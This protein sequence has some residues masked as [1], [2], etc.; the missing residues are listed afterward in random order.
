MIDRLTR[1][2]PPLVLLVGVCAAAALYLVDSDSYFTL[3]RMAGL[4]P[5]P[6]FLDLH[7]VMSAAECWQRGVDVY[8]ANPCDVLGRLHVYSPLWLRLPAWLVAPQMLTANG[9][10]MALG[11]I[12]A[13]LVL[14]RPNGSGRAILLLLAIVSPDTILALERANVDVL[15]FIASTIAATLLGRAFAQR[16]AGYGLFLLLGLLKFYP[17]VLLA[18]VLRERPAR[19]VALAAGAVTASLLVVLAMRD[20]FV[21]ALANIEPYHV[22]SGTFAA[23]QLP[24]GTAEILGAPPVLTIAL[25]LALVAGAAM[26]VRRLSGDAALVASIAALPAR[27]A[28]LLAV[29]APL[30]I[31]CFV[32]G[33]SVEYRAVF[34]LL[35]LPALFRLAGGTAAPRMFLATAAAIPALMWEPVLRRLAGRGYAPL[36]EAMTLPNLAVWLGREMLWWWVAAVLLGLLLAQFRDAPLPRM[37]LAWLWR[38][39]AAR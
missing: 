14:P 17:L 15:I 22:F 21:R 39:A 32:A 1:V 9:I 18:L 3:R 2:L 5:F 23:R 24:Q 4:Q 30:V 28:N 10:A 38:G 16:V 25:G 36:D 33:Q 7:G 12:M 11:F 20:E 37:G 34:L 31:G 6:L 13:L 19:A 26:L 8:A 29:G 35:T 27:E